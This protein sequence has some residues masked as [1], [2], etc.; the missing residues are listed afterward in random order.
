MSPALTVHHLRR[1]QSERVVWLCE[2]LG[3]PYNLK[4]YD[5]E[6]PALLAPEEYRRIHW[7]GTAPVIEDGSVV[8]AE[9][10]AIFEYIL[11]KYGNDRL[12]LPPTHPQ[13]ADY[14]FWLH[15]ANG[16]MQPGLI[17]L[18]FSRLGGNSEESLESKFA[19]KRV[20]QN[21]EGMDAQLAKFPYLGGDEFT[22]ADCISVFSLT[23]LRLFG[24]FSLEKY[25]NIVKYL[26]RISQ[27]EAYKRAM[28]KGDPGLEPVISAEAPKNTIW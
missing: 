11:T 26:E 19:Q 22:A 21:F 6:P 5:R 25:P 24:A 10:N 17:T 13:Y 27:R 2:E 8:L 15:R 12:S 18:M 28:E 1:S 3:I 7:S 23:T 20:D 16:A 9:S 14:L 4:S